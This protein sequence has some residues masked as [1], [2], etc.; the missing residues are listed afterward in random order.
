MKRLLVADAIGRTPSSSEFKTL[1][2]ASRWY[3]LTT[4]T[5][6]ADVIAPTELGLKV[7][8]PTSDEEKVSA[9]VAATLT[10]ELMGRVLRDYNNSKLDPG[11]LKN[12]LQRTYDVDFD[13]SEEL[14]EFLVTNAKYSGIL[15]SISGSNHILIDNPLSSPTVGSEDEDDGQNNVVPM[16]AT[17]AGLEKP[18]A[19]LATPVENKL[20]RKIFIAHGKNRKPME[21]LTK[22]LQRFG[23]PHV[24]AVNEAHGGRPISKKVADLM[25]ECS[26]GIFIFTK[27]ERFL[28]E[29]AKDNIEEVWRPSENV[30]F[31]LGAASVLWEKKIIIL[32]EDGVNF[33]SDFS[34]LGYITFHASDLA[35]NTESLL[36][37]LIALGLLKVSA[38]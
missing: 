18:A 16:D 31:E 1:L 11:F 35:S 6:K 8:R 3:G 14:A 23:V 38:A 30:V 15:R 33:P 21:S 36:A 29:G 24:V 20:P 13:H 37:E 28:R 9:L 7:I 12:T 27:D 5:E 34:D 4:G 2:S 25:E 17:R 10:P 32:R 22:L 26:A 19:P